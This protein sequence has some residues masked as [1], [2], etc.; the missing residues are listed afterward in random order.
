MPN[1]ASALTAAARTAE[2]QWVDFE[3]EVSYLSGFLRPAMRKELARN[4]EKD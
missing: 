3:E 4:R 1:L 2:G